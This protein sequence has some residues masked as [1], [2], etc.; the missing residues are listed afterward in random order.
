[1]AVNK[2][3]FGDTTVMDLTEDTVTSDTMLEGVT[4]HDK[5]GEPIVGSAVIPTVNNGK[6][7]IQKNGTTVATFTA[8]QS[9]AATANIT[10]PVK[11][12]ELTNDSNFV[13]DS[14][15]FTQASS[16][17]NIASGETFAT[18]LGKIKKFFTDLKTVAFTGSYNDLSDQPTIP[19]VNNA[20]LTIQKNGTTV[21]TFTANAS[22]NV[23]AN[24]TVPT[25]V[26]ELTND[27]GYTTNTGTVTSV[28]TGTG[29]TG[30]T[31]TSSG[32]I[33]IAD[34]SADYLSGGYLNVHPENTPTLI[35]FMN[36]DIA[37]L[38]K[39]GGSAVVKYDG[40]TQSVD[41]TNCFD[42]SPSYWSM[43]PTDITTIVVEL[44]LHKVFTYTNT[45]YV[46]F[47][48][49]GWRAKNVKIEVMNSNYTQDVWTQKYNNTN[50]SLGHCYVRTSHTPAG[51]SGAGGGFNKV[52]FTF[53]SWNSTQFRIAQMGIYN[54]GSAGLR[55]T[56]LPKD[57]GNIYGTIY[58]NSNNGADLGTSS[59][60]WNNAYITNINGVT[61][62]DSPKFTDNDTKNTAGS[63]NT[64]SKIFLIGA[65][66][67][68]ANP[69][70]YSHDTA[71]VGTDGCLYSGGT[72][73]LT[74]HQ[75]ISGKVN[76]SGDTMTNTLTIQRTGTHDNNYPASL[77][78][79][80]VD[81][82]NSV[83][84]KAAISAYDGGASG[85]NMVINP[86]GNLFIGSGEGGYNH[87][88]L[89]KHNTGENLYITADSVLHLQSNSQTIAN[90]VGAQ[91]TTAG[92]IV[93]EAA[94]VAT[95]NIGG[96]GTSAYRWANGYFTNL[97][98]EGFNR[99][100]ITGKTLDLDTLT[101]KETGSPHAE[102]YIEK[103]D[104]GAANIT[105]RPVTANKPFLLD[106]EAIRVNTASDFITRQTYRNAANPANEYVRFCTNGT[107]TAWTTRVFTDT[108]Y[109]AGS[110]ITLNGTTFSLTK[111]NVTGALGYT[112]P[113]SDTNTHRP[114]QVN[115]TEILG[116]N[117]TALNL[118]AG[119][120]V[121]VTNSSGTVTIAA[122]DTTYS[123]GSNITLSGT[124]F[125][126]T[127]ANVTGALGY[128]P[129][130]T[131]TKN[132]A[133]S[134]NTSSK[135]FLIGATSQ[136]ANPQTYSDD[137]VYATSGTL[138]T[139][140]LSSKALIA[141]TGTGTAGSDKGSGVSPRYIPS[142]WTFNSGV[143]VA[144]GEVYLIKIPV[145]GG[146]YGVWL[147]LNNGTNYYPVAISNGTTRFTTQYGN[148]TVIAVTYESAGKCTCYPKDGGDATSSVT[149][150]FRVLNDY[151]ANSNV[152]QTATTTNANYE[153]LFSQT[154]D[155]TTRTEGA[156]KTS[157]FRFN[158]STNTLS[159]TN[160]TLNGGGLNLATLS[161]SSDNSAEIIFRYGD[162]SMKAA[163][164][165]ED[166]LT[167]DNMDKGPL[168][169]TRSSDGQ[170]AMM[171]RL[172]LEGHDLPLTGGDLTGPLRI[173]SG[174]VLYLDKP[175]NSNR[176]SLSTSSNGTLNL[177]AVT[178][179]NLCTPQQVQCRNA[180]DSG[181]VNIAAANI[182]SSR[183]F[184]ENI[185]DLTEEEA[186]KLLDV[187]T[188][189]FDFKET[190]APSSDW[191][192]ER[193]NQ[194]GVIAEEVLDI[195]PTLV[196]Y[197]NYENPD[198]D[199]VPTFVEY[200]HFVPYLIKMVQ[201]QQKEIDD[202]KV[203][204]KELQTGE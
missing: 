133:G 147:S 36:N 155:N 51:A 76:K 15:T 183:R 17:A 196:R 10:V 37:Y 78:L 103:T 185:Q 136:A 8:N 3:V 140:K 179:L 150:I 2:V 141:L 22:S 151:D 142:L 189:T 181:W 33:S 112:P 79:W 173:K 61:V 178:W 134:T 85:A 32:T 167:E 135:I 95:N 5:S 154:A 124:T 184:K 55:E 70:T 200:S 157:T 28:A 42:A 46:D 175:D 92:D 20:T 102:Y 111:A 47:G 44:T 27:S 152:T 49:A 14:P 96:I 127:K 87:Y 163:I 182:E 137:Q 122:T 38:L 115:G 164:S 166:E 145:A 169:E 34:H 62:G 191:E 23:T 131:D 77:N 106:V 118:K 94:D 197:S 30:G 199:P 12:S 100:D 83:T 99:I 63:T 75:D 117:T 203:Q 59:K 13:T 126:L 31:I 187:R 159:T 204:I 81:S 174:N 114:I 177:H 97:D 80:T 25:K 86:N 121:S 156:R 195:Y 21:K 165:M 132:T 98:A 89:Y 45:I 161:S 40:T 192:H 148:N 6:L 57:G 60:Y 18:I 128:T 93:P 172:A 72:K 160:L 41:L 48:S 153:V 65:T 82:T 43:N 39:R 116:N 170:L 64:S 146:T 91:V 7:T 29:L 66:S 130:T 144:N 193:F 105:N 67:Q 108:T 90:R 24:I 16:R 139:N 120:N 50:N 202:L 69:Q 74:A 188:V 194:C 52:R 104:G 186:R 162:G 176:S 58:P 107:W 73:V 110:N 1:M 101:L 11:V 113:T 198:E 71:Y 168:Y 53:S 123:A 149:G 171:T 4:A 88:T 9:T 180:T 19:T 109:S 26:S 190:Y 119:S 158:P 56:F 143:T 35:P 201:M 138:T 84:S 129:P 54:Y 68:A 125:S